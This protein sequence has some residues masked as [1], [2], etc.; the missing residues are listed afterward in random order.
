M[1]SGAG[2]WVFYSLIHTK[3]YNQ[4]GGCGVQDKIFHMDMDTLWNCTRM[5]LVRISILSRTKPSQTED[6]HTTWKSNDFV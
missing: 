2:S 6:P 5:F 1:G 4:P 3:W